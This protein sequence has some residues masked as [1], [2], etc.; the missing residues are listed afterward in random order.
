MGGTSQPSKQRV[1]NQ[2]PRLNRFQ[3]VV[4]A[5]LKF[6]SRCAATWTF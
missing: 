2:T 1:F 5:L 3:E 6:D 4:N